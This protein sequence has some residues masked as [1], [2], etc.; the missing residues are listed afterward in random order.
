MGE[1]FVFVRRV[2]D[3]HDVIGKAIDEAIVFERAAVVEDSGVVDLVDLERGDVVG[4]HVVHELE[5]V[6]TGDE[7][8]AH[9]ADVEEAALMADGVVFGGDAGGV[10]DGHFEAREGY[11]FS[12]ECDVEVVEWSAFQHLG[13][14]MMEDRRWKIEGDAGCRTLFAICQGGRG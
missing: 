3:H 6:W 10:L 2:H 12:A 13:T 4:R 11:H 9:V 5:R 8:F 14:K 7:E 1:V